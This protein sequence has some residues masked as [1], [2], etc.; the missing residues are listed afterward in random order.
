MTVHALPKKHQDTHRVRTAMRGLIEAVEIQKEVIKDFHEK[1]DKLG[2]SV[3][4][5]NGTLGNYSGKL[6]GVRK[7]CL[8]TREM[9]PDAL[10]FSTR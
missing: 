3:R 4:K 9:M 2:H 6:S 10:A 7:K 1:I 5:I 8:N